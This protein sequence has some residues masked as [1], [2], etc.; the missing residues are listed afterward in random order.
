MCLCSP[1][2]VASQPPFSGPA[3]GKTSLTHPLQALP[4]LRPIGAPSSACALLPTFQLMSPSLE[5]T[6]RLGWVW[7]PDMEQPGQERWAAANYQQ[8]PCGS[9]MAPSDRG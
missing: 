2:A 1:A 4:T 8:L 9:G 7:W 5:E 3:A 6:L